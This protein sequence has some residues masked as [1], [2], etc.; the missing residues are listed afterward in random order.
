MFA[1]PCYDFDIPLTIN[2]KK[3]EKNAPQ[4]LIDLQYFNER[5]KM[6]AKLLKKLRIYGCVGSA[7]TLGLRCGGY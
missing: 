1:D 3:G 4:N 6:T 5:D 2:T 7:L